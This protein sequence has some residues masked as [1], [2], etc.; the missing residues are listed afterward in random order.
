MA[1]ISDYLVKINE[2]FTV[3]MYN[4]GFMFCASGTDHSD[5]WATAK[6]VCATIEDVILLVREAAMLPRN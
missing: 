2:D 6:I 1:K 5:N 3:N 4:N